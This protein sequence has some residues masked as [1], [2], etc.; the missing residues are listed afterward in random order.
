M[1]ILTSW[2]ACCKDHRAIL[3]PGERGEVLLL[4]QNL[5]QAK[6]TL[7]FVSGA[8]NGSSSLKPLVSET[9]ADKISLQ[10]G[11]DIIV[12]PA[13]YRSARGGTSIAV[14]CDEISAWRDESSANP[15]VEIL[16]AVR[17]SLL[18]TKRAADRD[19][20]AL[21]DEGR[22]L[23][24]TRQILRQSLS[25]HPCRAGRDPDYESIGDMADID[26]AFLDDPIAASAE[27]GALF[28]AELDALCTPEAVAAVTAHGVLERAYQQG[29]QYYAFVDPA[30]GRGATR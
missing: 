28:R 8:L 18:T 3:G 1:A 19:L 7:N 2:L 6:R 20:I 13:S 12:R 26:Q 5:D 27:F 23:Q 11:I 24:R 9:T 22:A 17:P 15:D 10:T 30:A 4:A 16:R 21:F 29:V 14:I 25:P